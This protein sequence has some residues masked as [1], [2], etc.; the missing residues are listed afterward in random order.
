VDSRESTINSAI[1]PATSAKPSTSGGGTAPAEAARGRTP[2]A[3]N[4]SGASDSST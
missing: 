3:W 2:A 4:A 1:R